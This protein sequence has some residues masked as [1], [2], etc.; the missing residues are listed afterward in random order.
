VKR[1]D[2]D[3]KRT[4]KSS[5]DLSFNKIKRIPPRVLRKMKELKHLYFA[6]N[7]IS[8]IEGL[9]DM[10]SLENLELGANRIRVSN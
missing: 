1:E 8:V 10:D 9:E 4:I 3:N 5:L 2:A 6:A 7:K